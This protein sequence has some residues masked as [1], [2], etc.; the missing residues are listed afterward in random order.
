MTAQA[1]IDGLAEKLRRRERERTREA[2]PAVEIEADD[3]TRLLVTL[4]AHH[5]EGCID[6]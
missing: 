6:A 5:R 3:G 1:L 4:S 2:M